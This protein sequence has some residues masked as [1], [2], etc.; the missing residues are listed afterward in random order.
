MNGLYLNV[1][2][3]QAI[4]ITAANWCVNIPNLVLNCVTKEYADEVKDLGVLIDSLLNWRSHARFVAAKVFARLRGLWPHASY[5][6][7][8]AKLLLV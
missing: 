6:P 2:K 8:S 5:L 1:N 3:T 4:K 7:R